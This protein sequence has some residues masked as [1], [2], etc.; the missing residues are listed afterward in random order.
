[1]A[2][3]RTDARLLRLA[4]AGLLLGIAGSDV[5]P[6]RGQF[7]D[8]EAE[9]VPPGMAE[10]DPRA[11]PPGGLPA[12]SELLPPTGPLLGNE[13]V[14][15]GPE[16]PEVVSAPPPVQE[17]IVDVRIVGNR[18]VSRE[19]FLREVRT[20]PGR[21]FDLPTV[22]EDVRRLNATRKFLDVKTLYERPPQGGIVVIFQV[23][24]R[25]ML[26][27]VRYLGNGQIKSSKLAKET[28]LKPGDPLDPY[29]VEEGRRKIEELYKK[30]GFNRI[31][32]TVLQGNKLGD[33]GAEYL[34]NEGKSQQVWSIK[35]EGNTIASDAR[36]QTQIQT[37]RPLFYIFK[38]Y[39]DHQKIEGDIDRLTAYYRSLGF[40]RARVA[41]ELQFDDDQKWLT[42]TFVIDEGPRY[43]VRSVSF[44]G[45]KK[46]DSEEWAG[47]LKLNNGQFFDQ[48]DLVADQ[49]V[50]QDYYGG[51]GYIF[52]D[53][54]A[55]P[56]F[57]EEPGTLD[58]VYQINEGARYRVGRI[59]VRVH[60]DHPHTRIRTA[61]NRLDL[62]PGDIV[63]TRKI[64]DAERRL[65]YSQLFQND[66]AQGIEPRIVLVPPDEEAERLA[67]E[68]N[69]KVR[70]QSPDGH[71]PDRIINLGI[72][73]IP[74]VED[75]APAAAPAPLVRGQTP[76]VRRDPAAVGISPRRA[77]TLERLAG[78]RTVK[79]Q[80]STAPRPAVAARR[81]VIRGQYTPGGG[82][83]LPTLQPRTPT[84][85]Y[86]TPVQP[87]PQVVEQHF[88]VTTDDGTVVAQDQPFL[89][90]PGAEQPE[91]V[92]APGPVLDPN[93]NFVPFGE[94]GPPPVVEEPDRFIDPVID[95]TETQTGR[96]MFGV[97]VNS[98]AGVVGSIVLDEQNFDFMRFPRSWDDFRTATAFR[99][100]GQQLRIEAV[101][102]T[103]LQR[104]VINF[105]EP[106]LFD[107]PVSLGL[108]GFY[109]T[110]GYTDWLEQRIG[111]R[112]SLGYQLTP[113]LSITAAVRA[114]NVEISNPSNA[115]V[116]LLAEALGDNSLYGFR[117]QLAHDT[118][119]SA[120]LPTEGHY[121]E[122]AGEQ[123]VGTFMYPIGTA[124]AKQY[125]M[126]HQRPD[127][128][129]RHV[130]SVSGEVGFAGAGAPIYDRFY[131]GGFS[132]LRGFRFRG[133]SPMDMGVT[134]GG[135]FQ[136]LGSVEY[137][138]PL[139]PDDAMRAVA[140]CDYGTVENQ[141]E[142]NADNFRVAPGF[143]FRISVPG[144]GPAPI[145]LD[146]AFP[147]A[148]AAT[149]RKQVFSFFVGLLR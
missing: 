77:A 48:A 88:P 71:A 13:G 55:D 39:V 62:R 69:G 25:P 117:L 135:R 90:P 104:Y 20:R 14:P 87:G 114:E 111:G 37:K 93:D 4:L 126:V 140:F 127:R 103:Q 136:L 36:L 91:T 3:L 5:A 7:P 146:F 78:E 137:M 17:E 9:I 49:A 131:A 86:T 125:F 50:I 96:L 27:F 15:A 75:G 118:R 133:A 54:Q 97:G 66:P 30:K 34:I 1:M 84:Y 73:G 107:T 6:V 56:R 8:Y 40:F 57:L 138:F 122:I 89:T 129:G 100:A 148:Y 65:K 92:P 67:E 147:V 24:E 113:D 132:S 128:S 123:V 115:A 44:V 119:D 112:V 16:P 81:P 139:S 145:A 26:E 105:R 99:G 95:V 46:F 60:G 59:D 108:S 43:V 124:T 31:Q 130:I 85:R 134:V 106:Y 29:A 22:E 109:F 98:D 79:H 38:G 94:E 143:G 53:V 116:P 32:V 58:L 42:V 142:I 120:F 64:R 76:D 10:P 102:G 23:V 41:R 72:D 28:E 82:Q 80:P 74:T 101:P 68:Q 18:A 110:R 45:N 144:M 47:K 70:G 33:R 121:V 12:G 2:E 141:I 35:F 149:D 83:A 63:D 21:P 61:L 11:I 52:A 19:K 51:R